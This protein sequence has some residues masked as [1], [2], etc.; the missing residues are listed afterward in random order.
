MAA[1]ASLSRLVL[2]RVGTGVLRDDGNGTPTKG[3]R[4][5]HKT[6]HAACGS[7]AQA[8]EANSWIQALVWTQAVLDNSQSLCVSQSV[9][10]SKNGDTAYTKDFCF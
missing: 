10:P 3:G 7:R 8:L 5:Q 9:L 4:K 6:G 1:L 2:Q